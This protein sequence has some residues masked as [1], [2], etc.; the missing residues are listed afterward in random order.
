M[1]SINNATAQPTEKKAGK[2]N[3]AGMFDLQTLIQAGID[4]KTGLPIKA[5]NGK[6]GHYKAG[7]KA[8]LRIMDSA[9]AVNRYV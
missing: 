5:V 8:L 1:A 9:D 6:D 3:N 7:V 4:P 2:I